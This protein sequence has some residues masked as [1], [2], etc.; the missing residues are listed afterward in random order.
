M[1]SE[2]RVLSGFGSKRQKAIGGWRTFQ[3]EELQNVYSSL[4]IR[5]IKSGNMRLVRH[6]DRMGAEA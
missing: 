2:N 6:V 1:V 3:T 4:N 5:M